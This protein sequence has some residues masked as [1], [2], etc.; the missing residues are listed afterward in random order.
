MTEMKS[1]IEK[2]SSV[3]L[4]KSAW[5]DGPWKEE[6]DLQAWK[7]EVGYPALIVRNEVCG[8]LCGYVFINDKHPWHGLEF[9]HDSCKDVKVHGGLNYSGS[10]LAPLGMKI[11]AS[12][13]WGFGFDCGHS[14][15]YLPGMVAI[16]SSLDNNP[17]TQAFEGGAYRD[18]A[19]AME[20]CESLAAQLKMADPSWR[21]VDLDW[22]DDQ[23]AAPHPPSSP[24]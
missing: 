4:D 8:N 10:E 14:Y 9:T 3:L 24:G 20:Q 2:P 1:L 19:Y 13:L 18:V 23:E 22:P 17:F 21:S 5:P 7:T 12:P 15:D 6:P 11:D 16:I